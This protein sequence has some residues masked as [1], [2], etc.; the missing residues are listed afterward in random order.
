MVDLSQSKIYP[1]IHLIKIIKK[2]IPL[3]NKKVS[4]IKEKLT[5]SSRQKQ[6][7]GFILL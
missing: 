6:L 7:K 3:K 5:A 1:K 4:Q 2:R